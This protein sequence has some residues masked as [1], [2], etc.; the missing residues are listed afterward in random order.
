[1]RTGVEAGPGVD[2]AGD[3]TGAQAG[4]GPGVVTGAGVAGPEV[5]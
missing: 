3:G 5:V 1:M 4:E 2:G